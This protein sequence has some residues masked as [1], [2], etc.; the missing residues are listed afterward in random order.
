MQRHQRH[1]ILLLPA[2]TG[3]GGQLVQQ[4]I[5]ERVAVAVGGQQF[6][7]A[8]KA[9]HLPLRIVRLHQ[10]VAVE[11]HVFAGGQRCLFFV[12]THAGHQAQRHAGGPQLHHAVGGGVVGHV[13]P[14]VGVAQM[15]GGRIEHGVEAGNKHFGRNFLH[16][17]VVGAG[18]DCA[19]RF[20]PFRS[21]AQQ[22]AGGGHHQGGGHPFVRHISDD[23]TD[24]A[25]VKIDEVIKVATDGTG[26]L[27]VGGHAPAVQGGQLLRQQ[28]LLDEPRH[29]QLLLDA[30]PLGRFLLLLLDQLGHPQRGRGLRGQIGQQLVVVAGIFLL[31]E[32]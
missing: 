26:R 17:H 11:Q 9:K 15:T 12:V 19:G 31:A 16:Q 13:V 24:T 23:E 5:F 32:A 2:R 20:Q 30:L 27:V 29:F 14:G 25:V 21:S 7:Q 18:Q 10:A 1:I 3:E 4:K 8:G 28:G 6:L 22:S